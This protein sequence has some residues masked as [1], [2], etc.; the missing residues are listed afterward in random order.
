V[1]G[2]SC[3]TLEFVQCGLKNARHEVTGQPH[4]LFRLGQTMVRAC[5]KRRGRRKEE[6]TGWCHTTVGKRGSPWL[7]HV[8]Q[9]DTAKSAM[10][11]R[12]QLRHMEPSARRVYLAT[13]TE[14]GLPSGSRWDSIG[15]V[16]TAPAIQS[17]Q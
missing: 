4:L 14:Q 8:F 3:E 5:F 2:I 13:A 6:Q 11:D 10:M 12:L 9:C 15:I 16:H 17:N 7:A 1:L